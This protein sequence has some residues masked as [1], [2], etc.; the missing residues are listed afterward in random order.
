M[1][2]G[3]PR[4]PEMRDNQS[5]PPGAPI[6]SR[7]MRPTELLGAAVGLYRRHWRTLLP[8]VAIAVPVAVSMPSTRALPAPGGEYQVVV[9]HRVVATAGS[10]A[11]TAVVVLATLLGVLGLAVVAGAVTRAAVAAAGGEDL[12]I[13]R[14]YRFAVGR[15]GPLLAVLVLTWLLV[16]IGLLLLVVPGVVIGVQLAVAVP[17]LVAEGL[18]P[19]KALA[20]SGRL[21]RGHWWHTFGTLLATWLLLGLA[22]NL[23]DNA[24]GGLGHHWAAETVAQGLAITL[25]APYAVLVLA[26]LYLDLR[27]REE[28][29]DAD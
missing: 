14:S 16:A 10:W 29:P 5:R 13:R 19:G 24:G 7:P 12:G 11:D 28:P 4:R 25:V 27:A 26:L 22:V 8:I 20:R 6:G 17:A 3:A 1:T 9:H 2:N 18:G 21:V 15:V 23:V